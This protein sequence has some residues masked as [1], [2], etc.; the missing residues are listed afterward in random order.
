MLFLVFL[1]KKTNRF[2]IQRVI[3]FLAPLM[4][5]VYLIHDNPYLRDYI[6]IDLLGLNKI[7]ED[8]MILPRWLIS[9]IVVFF[10]CILLDFFRLL[11]FRSWENR[12]WFKKLMKQIDGIPSVIISQI[13]KFVL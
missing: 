2:I 1:R 11:V 12:L 5:G 3:S 4:F 7:E 6:W 10:S 13:E 9:V 8:V